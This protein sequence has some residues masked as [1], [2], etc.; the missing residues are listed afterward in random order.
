MAAYQSWVSARRTK[1][2][3][4]ALLALCVSAA[5]R[6]FAEAFPPKAN[7]AWVYD[8]QGKADQ[9]SDGHFAQSIAHY[10]AQAPH[11]A[12]IGE[13][14][15]YG[16]DMEMYCP[17]HEAAR[18][19]PAD[20]HVYYSRAS[21]HHGKSQSGRVINTSVRAY[22][23]RLGIQPDS[24][25]MIVSPVIDGAITKKGALGGFDELDASKAKLF[26]DKVARQVCADPLV[27]G[28][29][30]DLEPF[31]V[32]KKAG[33]YYFFK[34]IARAFSSRN[35][36]C[37]DGQHPH[38]RFFSIF[39]SANRIRPHSASA[40]HVREIMEVAHNGYLI[41]SLYDLEGTPA[42]HQTPLNVYRKLV[43][44][45]TRQMRRWA[46]QLG[47]DY[48]FAIPAAAAAHEYGGC[49]GRGCRPAGRRQQDADPDQMQLQYAKAAVTAI[50]ASGATSDAHWLGDALWA[51]SPDIEHG[52]M[53][54]SP[55]KPP[56]R[57]R[58]YLRGQL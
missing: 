12:R 20:F 50:R 57:V 53:H 34:G 17:H 47:I 5:P 54:F 27:D 14:Y 9:D 26:A 25:R 43:R 45:Q 41:A 33:Q 4:I 52:G 31:N 2:L 15:I 56:A 13:L 58:R 11:K 35:T 51:W 36:G 29:Q 32:K 3:A 21:R 1:A 42:G 18:C 10:N 6:A 55:K 28:I 22:A 7:A 8:P 19:Q 48:Q 40:R 23:K 38:G 16:G 46:D 30:F 39:T 37:V 44:R 49:H 24:R